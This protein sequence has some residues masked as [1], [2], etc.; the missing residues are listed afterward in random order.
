MYVSAISNRF[1]RGRSTPERRAMRAGA[2]SGF[3]RSAACPTRAARA[4]APASDRGWPVDPEPRAPG[5]RRITEVC[6]S[7]LAL[8]VA[9]VLA[10]HHD[11]AVTA[12]HL[13]L[14]ADRLDARVDLHGRAISSSVPADEP[15]GGLL[16]AVDDAPA[17]QVVRRQ[18]H[19]DAILRQDA[20]VVL[21]HLAA[22][23][24]EDPVSVGQFDPEHRVGKRLDDATLDLDG[25]VLLWHVL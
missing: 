8:L 19:H 23:V 16:V 21:A 2:P 22:D 1:S 24:G 14:V 9:Q 25:S 12:D 20:D 10:D 3:R 17:G 18:L 4:R 11:P 6:R 5:G 13:A 15:A 7:A